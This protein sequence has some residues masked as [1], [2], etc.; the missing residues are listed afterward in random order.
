MGGSD[1]RRGFGIEGVEPTPDNP[2]RMHPRT[3]TPTYFS[4]MGIPI[5]SGR[6][7][8]TDDHANASP[9]VVI[10]EASAKRFW[11]GRDPVGIR[12]AFSD[13]IWRTI[14]GVSG[15]VRHWGLTVPTNPMVYL[16]Q[17]QMVSSSLTFVLKTNLDPL[18]LTSAAK[19][20]VAGFDRNIP[21]GKVESLVELVCRAVQAERAQTVRMGAFGVLALALAVVGIYGVMAQLA[22]SRVH[23]IGVRMAL[24]ARP[25]HVLRQLLFEGFVQAALGLV[26]GLGAGVYLMRFATTLLFGIE[27]SDVITL[28]GVTVTLL[29]AALAACLIPARR[30]MRIDPVEAL[31][32]Q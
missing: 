13:T 2:R 21:V 10:S 19:S 3:V 9:V 22:L 7:F 4:T 32:A 16:P 24:G 20:V 15:D 14:V 11:P 31:R 23:E 30:A 28:A 26:I 17:E 6:G 29:L 12:I 1:S 27:P 18:S 8:T 25:G 5:V